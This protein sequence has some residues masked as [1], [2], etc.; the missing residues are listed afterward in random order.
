MLEEGIEPGRTGWSASCSGGSQRFGHHIH[1]P[2]PLFELNFAIDQ[3]EQ[4][5]VT[6]GA[7]VLTGYEPGA[8]LANDDA[9]RSDRLAA[10][11]LYAEPFTDAVAAV[12]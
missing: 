6:T 1:P 10:K 7:D 11:P 12:S 9:A 3:G 2:S 5:P 8:A 4:G